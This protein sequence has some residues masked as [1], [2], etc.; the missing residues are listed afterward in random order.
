MIKVLHIITDLGLGGAETMLYRLL[1]RMDSA[2][3][4]N[5]VI[6]LT[7]FGGNAENIRAAGVP[8]RAVGMTKGIPNLFPAARLLRSIRKSKPQIVQTW[9]YHANLIGGLTA[10]FAADIPVVWGIHHAN[11]DRQGNKRLTIWI[12]RIYGSKTR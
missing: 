4:K 12:A 8:V 10:R 3:F 2:R 11:L 6:S 5:E 1:S 7:N 9:M